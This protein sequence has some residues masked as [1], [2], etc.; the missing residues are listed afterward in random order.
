MN[1]TAHQLRRQADVAR[2]RALAAASRGRL[3]LLDANPSG[4][5]PIRIEVQCRTVTG[6]EYPSRAGERTRIRI[7]LPA[8]YPFERPAVTIESPIF[9][10]NVFPSGVVCQGDR[11]IPS[12]GLDLLVRRMIRLVTYDPAHV[13]PASAANRSAA[14]WYLAQRSRGSAA[15]PSDRLVFDLPEADPA[16]A[17]RSAAAATSAA[18]SAG[19]APSTG[20][21]PSA[22]AAPSVGAAPSASAA[23]RVVRRCP[24]CAQA[25]RLPAGRSG[26]VACP[27]CGREVALST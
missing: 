7:N 2:L 21:A 11:W 9:H 15:F 4:G 23:A 19:A 24:H 12:E 8:R 10:P 6:A 27:G 20:A 22:G 5:A 13:N 26:I 1:A 25:M 3:T 14:N 18:P 17:A 16:L